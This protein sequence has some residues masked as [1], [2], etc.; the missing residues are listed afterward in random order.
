MEFR[1]KLVSHLYDATKAGDDYKLASELLNELQRKYNCDSEQFYEALEFLEDKGYIRGEATRYRI[2]GSGKEYVEREIKN[3][4]RNPEKESR[5][6]QDISNWL[7][8][9]AVILTACG[10]WVTFFSKSA[11]TS[12]T[13]SDEAVNPAVSISGLVIPFQN[14]DAAHWFPDPKQFNP[15]YVTEAII[16]EP[17]DDPGR[18]ASHYRIYRHPSDCQSDTIRGVLV[19][20]IFFE[21]A[22]GSSGYFTAAY[23]SVKNTNPEI[24]NS[25]GE[26]S[27]FRKYMQADGHCSN[28]TSETYSLV[29]QRNNAIGIAKTWIVPNS[30]DSET[31]QEWLNQIARDLDEKFQESFDE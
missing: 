5:Q 13:R 27:Y 2:T 22:A 23:E 21:S 1:N 24:I 16:S 25:A 19:Q 17:G 14:I 18:E 15:E 9:L 31:I 29:F 6:K 20:V 11:D 7:Q 12:A 28:E 10:I 8:F 3:T 4:V 30:V 26:T